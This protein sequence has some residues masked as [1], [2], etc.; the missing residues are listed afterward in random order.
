MDNQGFKLLDVAGQRSERKKWIPYFADATGVIFV[1]AISEYDQVIADDGK[2]NR[3]LEC[4]HLFTEIMNNPYFAA[5]PIVLFLNKCD[6]FRDKIKRIPL[7]VCFP[8]YRGEQS[9]E[10]SQLYKT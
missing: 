4:I 7:N 8:K 2:S 9:Y 5:T 1:A 6:L 10:V 3:L